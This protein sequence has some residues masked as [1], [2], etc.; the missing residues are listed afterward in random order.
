M[1]SDRLIL[2]VIIISHN[3]QRIINV[4]KI[5]FNLI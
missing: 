3:K 5:A 4:V 2:Y 1:M